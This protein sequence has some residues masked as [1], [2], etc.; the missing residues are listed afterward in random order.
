MN[1]TVTQ[2]TA[3]ADAKVISFAGNWLQNQ[4]IGQIEIEIYFYHKVGTI[5]DDKQ[6]NSCRG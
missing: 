6:S 5:F 2:R 3:D 4:S 1:G